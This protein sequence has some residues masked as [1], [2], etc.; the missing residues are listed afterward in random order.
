M[1]SIQANFRFISILLSFRCCVAWYIDSSCSTTAIPGQRYSNFEIVHRA[2]S[3][4]AAMIIQTKNEMEQFGSLIDENTDVRNLATYVFGSNDQVGWIPAREYY[5]ALA[6]DEVT[7]STTSSL[8][9]DG[10]KIYCSLSRWEVKTVTVNNAPVKRSKDKDNSDDTAEIVVDADIYAK[11]A[12][13]TRAATYSNPSKIESY[14][15]ICPKI[16]DYWNSKP[17]PLIQD[18]VDELN[19]VSGSGKI[20]QGRR[21]RLDDVVR[22]EKTMLHEVCGS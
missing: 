5:R 1:A 4:A 7:S 20:G 8:L 14:I 18:L 19:K 15:Q 16:V 13:T 17:L 10:I 2:T 6:S 21:V 22:L 9:P 12:G 3:N 11:C